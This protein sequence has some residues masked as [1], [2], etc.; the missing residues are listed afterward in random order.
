MFFGN[1]KHV[2]GNRNI[3][4]ENVGNEVNMKHNLSSGKECLGLF[5]YIIFYFH[6]VYLHS[7]MYHE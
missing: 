2:F 4:R 3:F 7:N 5:R 1:H 6:D